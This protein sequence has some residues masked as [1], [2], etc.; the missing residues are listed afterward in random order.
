I[1]LSFLQQ[2]FHIHKPKVHLRFLFVATH[3]VPSQPLSSNVSSTF[4]GSLSSPFSLSESP[5]S[6][7][8]NSIHFVCSRRHAAASLLHDNRSICAKDLSLVLTIGSSSE[9]QFNSLNLPP[10]PPLVI[11]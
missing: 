5:T 11:G 3:F 6:T 10:V 2:S 9:I 8:M 7:L 1:Q 4:G